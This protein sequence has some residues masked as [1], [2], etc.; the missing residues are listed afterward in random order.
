MTILLGVKNL[1][2]FSAFKF[3]DLTVSDGL[4]RKLSVPKHT[5]EF[6]FAICEPESQAVIYVLCSQ[7]FI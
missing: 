3:D 1:W 5:K 2:P 6:V 7:I 4:V